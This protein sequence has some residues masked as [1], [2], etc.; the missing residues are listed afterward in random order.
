MQYTPESVQAGFLSLRFAPHNATVRGS[1]S[2][3]S[4]APRVDEPF[5]RCSTVPLPGVSTGL[6]SFPGR[7]QSRAADSVLAILEFS[8]WMRQERMDWVYLGREKRFGR[9]RKRIGATLF[10]QLSPF[11]CLETN[12]FPYYSRR[13]HELDRGLRQTGVFEF[14]LNEIRPRVVFVHGKSAVLH[15]AGLTKAKLPMG[16]F[17]PPVRHTQVSTFLPGTISHITG[18]MLRSAI[19]EKRSRRGGRRTQT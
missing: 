15:V 12:V 17:V 14:L 11:G 1:A 16:R 5:E 10:C 2:I 13:E 9:T 19:S 3:R 4:Q 7:H 8:D 6:R 18:L